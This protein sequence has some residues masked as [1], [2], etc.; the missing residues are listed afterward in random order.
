MGIKY[1]IQAQTNINTNLHEVMPRRQPDFNK[2]FPMIWM[3]GNI[4]A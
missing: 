4:Y 3:D 1:M 2:Y